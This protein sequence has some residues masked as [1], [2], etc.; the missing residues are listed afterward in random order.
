LATV[1]W[2]IPQE[3]VP[4]VATVSGAL[5]TPVI[6]TIASIAARVGLQSRIAQVDFLLKRLDLIKKALEVEAAFGD[7]LSRSDAIQT[8]KAEYVQAVAA[9]AAFARE[10]RARA[11]ERVARGRTG[12]GA[13]ALPKPLSAFDWMPTVS[14][15]LYV[16][17]SAIYLF[18]ALALVIAGHLEPA[19]LVA[20]GVVVAHGIALLMRYW[21][22][23]NWSRHHAA[24]S[25]T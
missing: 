2:G 18:V 5:L 8:L 17:L 12:P 15:Y 6:G 25:G 21:A 3:Y 16:A 14:Y 1:F 4:L 7:R 11:I 10:D 19:L 24:S 13:W 9:I 20:A 23:R 22:L